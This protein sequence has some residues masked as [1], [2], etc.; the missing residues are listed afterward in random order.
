M[1]N[2]DR[3]RLIDVHGAVMR[4]EGAIPYLA[5]REDL[6]TAIRTHERSLHPHGVSDPPPKKKL[7]SLKAKLYAALITFLA[8]ATTALTIYAANQ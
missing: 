6:S 2:G 1:D 5:T 8:A 7:I 4:I 3:Q